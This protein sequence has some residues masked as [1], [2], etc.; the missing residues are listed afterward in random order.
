MKKPEPDETVEE[1][2]ARILEWLHE[3]NRKIDKLNE[4]LM[5]RSSGD[6]PKW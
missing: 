1:R 2:L 6:G 3:I 5:P 4:R